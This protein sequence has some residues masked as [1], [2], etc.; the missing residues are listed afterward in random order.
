MSV[1]KKRRMGARQT[2]KPSA[3]PRSERRR[4]P[5]LDG[6]KADQATMLTPSANGPRNLK[7]RTSE[8]PKT[9]QEVKRLLI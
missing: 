2:S 7:E 6:R 4:A 9:S 3:I 8:I 1:V 5:D